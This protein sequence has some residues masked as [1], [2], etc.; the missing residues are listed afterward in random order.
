MAMMKKIFNDYIGPAFLFV[1]IIA[2][3]ASFTLIVFDGFGLLPCSWGCH[4]GKP[5]CKECGVCVV[6]FCP[7]CGE[8]VGGGNYFSF[9]G[10]FCKECG[11]ALN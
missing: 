2:F 5:Y 3:F 4:K 8:V 11:A 6:S 1:L 9:P 10:S 7:S